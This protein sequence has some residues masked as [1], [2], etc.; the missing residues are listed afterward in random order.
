MAF[1]TNGA[2]S[3]PADTPAGT[4][5]RSENPARRSSP[6][7]MTWTAAPT[8]SS[9]ALK[10]TV[11]PRRTAV[12]VVVEKSPTPRKGPRVP[13]LLEGLGDDALRRALAFEDSVTSGGRTERLPD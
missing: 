4:G 8:K 7:T 11:S 12:K 1:S 13:G 10:T 5:N 3:V 2:G 9:G 6:S